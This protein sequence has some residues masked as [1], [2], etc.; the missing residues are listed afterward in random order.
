MAAA[1]DPSCREAGVTCYGLTSHSG[2]SGIT[3]SH[4]MLKESEKALTGWAIYPHKTK[5]LSVVNTLNHCDIFRK[6]VG[7]S[8]PSPL[9]PSHQTSDFFFL[10]ICM[11]SKP[12]QLQGCM[13]QQKIKYLTIAFHVYFS[14]NL[15]YRIKKIICFLGQLLT[16][17]IKFSSSTSI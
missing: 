2:G 11:T 8:R 15:G 4:F 13:L 17:L 10:N 16:S 9:I 1:P 3:S 12:L 14:V 6:R 7:Q 5:A